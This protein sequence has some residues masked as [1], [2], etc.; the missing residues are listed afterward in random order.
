MGGGGGGRGNI[1]HL[2]FAAGITTGLC[3]NFILT[4]AHKL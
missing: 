4:V 1:L 2:L 3:T